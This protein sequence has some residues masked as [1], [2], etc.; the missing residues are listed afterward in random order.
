MFL[1]SKS[2]RALLESSYNKFAFHDE[3]LPDWF[4]QDEAKHM[5][6]AVEELLPEEDLAEARA[7]LKAINSRTIKKVAEAKARKKRKLWKRMETARAKANQIANSED[8]SARGKAR[9]IAKLYAQAKDLRK[10]GKGK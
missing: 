8:I 10:K 4:S 3:G 2:K 1:K 9:E 5:R 6:P 7:Q